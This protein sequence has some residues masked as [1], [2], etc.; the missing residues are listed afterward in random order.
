MTTQWR[1]IS[2][3]LEKHLNDMVGL[4]DVAWSN[5][6]YSPTIGTLYIEPI[7]EQEDSEAITDEDITRGVY[8]IKIVAP[9]GEGKSEAVTMSDTLA[10]RFKQDTQMTYNG[11]TVQVLNV[12]RSESERNRNGWFEIDVKIEYFSFTARR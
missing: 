3:A 10:N 12:H 1:D 5:A 8:R 11:V 7:N 6:G 9:A 2:A 4:P